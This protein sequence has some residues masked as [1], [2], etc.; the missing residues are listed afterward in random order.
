MISFWLIWIIVWIIIVFIIIFYRIYSNKSNKSQIN[1]D[2]NNEIVDNYIKNIPPINIK[3]PEVKSNPVKEPNI[4]LSGWL[5]RRLNEEGWY[6]IKVNWIT[7][8]QLNSIKEI[9]L[10]PTQKQQ[11]INIKS[12]SLN[13]LSQNQK[14]WK[15]SILIWIILTIPTGIYLFF[16]LLK[17]EHITEIPILILGMWLILWIGGSIFNWYRN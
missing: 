1:Q 6:D 8:D 9:L 12:D 13:T 14:Q 17:W 10:K 3:L 16:S 4:P 2:K 15:Q 7:D 5:I 11:S